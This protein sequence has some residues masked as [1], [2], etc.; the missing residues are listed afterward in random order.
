MQIFLFGKGLA[1][2]L[3]YVLLALGFLSEIND[4]LPPHQSQATMWAGAGFG[5][6]GVLRKVVVDWLK[7]VVQK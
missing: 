2:V 3:G 6:F 7:I 4:V 1:T 5:A